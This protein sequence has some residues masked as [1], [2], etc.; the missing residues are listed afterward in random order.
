LLL[1]FGA[2]ARRR[3]NAGEY[4]LRYYRIRLPFTIKNS[5]PGAPS[6][7]CPCRRFPGAL[8]HFH[9]EKPIDKKQLTHIQGLTNS[10]MK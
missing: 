4:L 6:P 7:V 9:P 2:A 1:L 8:F 3:R 5:L 10:K